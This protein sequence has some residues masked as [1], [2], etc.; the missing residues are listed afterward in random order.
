[1]RKRDH[2]T[3]SHEAVSRR[4]FRKLARILPP[5][6][7]LRHLITPPVARGAAPALCSQRR[8]VG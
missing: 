7:S 1:M 4:Y 5:L 3:P 8:Q 6:L 2:E